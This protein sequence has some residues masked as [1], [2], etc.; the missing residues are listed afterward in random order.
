[1]LC[2]ILIV[3]GLLIMMGQHDRSEALFYYFRL[4]D[5]VPETHLLRLIEKHIRFAFVREKLKASYSDTGRPSI[6]PELLLRILLIGYLYGITSERKLVEELRM[7]LAWRWFTG[8]GFDQ[9]IPHHSTFS[10]NRHGRFQ[11]SK[12]FEELFEQIVLQC[13]EVGLVQGKHLSVDGSFVE[14]NA[15]KE[16]RI[17]REQLAEAAQVNQTVRQYLVELEQQNPTEEPVHQQNQVSTTDPDATYATKGGTPAR[18]GYYD[19]YLVDNHSCVIVGVQ[20]TA[21]RMSQETVAAQDMLTRFTQWQGREPESVAAD[22]TYGN[23][24]FLQWLADR[25]ITPY[26][27]TRDSIHRKNSP[28][29]GPERFT[30]QPDSKL[31]LSCR[32]ATQLWRSERSESHLRLYRDAQALWWVRTESAVYQ[33]RVPLSCHPHAG[34]SS[35][36]RPRTGRHARLCPCAT[37]TKESGGPVCGTQESDRAASLAPAQIEVRAGA[38]LP[39]SRGPEHQAASAVPQPTDNTYHGSCLLVEVRG[40]TRW[41]R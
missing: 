7:H 2:W 17:P 31:S 19:N 35:T 1:M 5:Q 21:A 6:D 29:Y 36:T 14:A 16:S 34:T 25:S 40:K 32:R 24:E 10:K 11:E 9:E 4:E 3:G 39:G 8:L 27:R 20:A 38:V 33:R 18:L 41:Q 13:V 26:M 12:L 23:G 37:G 30:Y 22:T 28:F 15:A